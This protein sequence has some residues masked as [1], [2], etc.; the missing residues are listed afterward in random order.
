MRDLADERGVR[1]VAS[2]QS[3]FGCAQSCC[4]CEPYI[5][6]MLRSRAVV[7]HT[8]LPPR[9]TQQRT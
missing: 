7:F 9:V 2:L 8:V 4:L 5:E 6:Q 1:D 3:V